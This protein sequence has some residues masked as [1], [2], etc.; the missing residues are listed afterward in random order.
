MVNGA[1]YRLTVYSVDRQEQ[2][3]RLRKPSEHKG[4]SVG[5]ERCRAKS[6]AKS[7]A[8]VGRGLAEVQPSK[9]CLKDCRPSFHCYDDDLRAVWYGSTVRRTF[10]QCGTHD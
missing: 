7:N 1:T 9:A 5:A 4:C 10:P 3:Q 6:L 2:I 8:C